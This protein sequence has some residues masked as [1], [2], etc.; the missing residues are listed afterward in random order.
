MVFEYPSVTSAGYISASEVSSSDVLPVKE[1]LMSN[2][3]PYKFYQVVEH[4]ANGS[5]ACI[6][7]DCNPVSLSITDVAIVNWYE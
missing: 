1:L 4:M 5:V 3:R 2:C 7:Q 6:D